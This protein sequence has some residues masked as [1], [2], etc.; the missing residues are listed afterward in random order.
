M[1]SGYL[2]KSFV[3]FHLDKDQPVGVT[4]NSTI[5]QRILCLDTETFGKSIKD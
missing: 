2:I 1:N 5:Y 3:E 4:F